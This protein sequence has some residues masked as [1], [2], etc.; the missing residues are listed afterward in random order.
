MKTKGL[1]LKPYHHVNVDSK[2]KLDC[3]MWVEFLQDNN[4]VCRPFIDFD[5]ETWYADEI[6]LS[7]DASK[8]ETLGFGAI[9]NNEY[10]YSM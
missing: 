1:T 3:K 8:S 7:S 6:N 9:F 2:T 10:T 4:S 5:K